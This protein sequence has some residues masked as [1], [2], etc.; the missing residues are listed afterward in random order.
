MR[1]HFASGRADAE[2]AACGS[3]LRFHTA[4]AWRFDTAAAWRFDT[5]A[6][7]PVLYCGRT[8]VFTENSVL[9][10]LILS[11]IPK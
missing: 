10:L 5:P 3:M 9:G 2:R 11:Y 1:P 4:A 6:A 7:R 8:S